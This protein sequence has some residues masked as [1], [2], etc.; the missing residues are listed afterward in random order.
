MTAVAP[1]VIG[2]SSSRNR[3]TYQKVAIIA[4]IVITISGTLTGIM[5][6]VNGDG[7]ESFLHQWTS[8]FVFASLIALPIGIIVMSLVSQLIHALLSSATDHFKNLIIG[9]VM[10]LLMESAMAASTAVSQVGLSNLNQLTAEWSQNFIAAI[11]VGLVIAILMTLV[12]KPKLQAFM[13]S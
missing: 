3:P 9:I 6:F 13:K 5:T 2:Q 4:F 12:V 1:R 7:N 8:A 11:P 10:A